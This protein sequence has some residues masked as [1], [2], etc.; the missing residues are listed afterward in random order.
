MGSVSGF[1][2]RG[3]RREGGGGVGRNYRFF[4][5]Q[6]FLPLL[7][8][9]T[10]LERTKAVGLSSAVALSQVSFYFSLFLF[11]NDTHSV[12]RVPPA[13]SGSRDDEY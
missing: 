2:A 12:L 1:V 13:F 10:R 8:Y 6:L 4:W 9:R 11:L 7:Q 5:Q 3:E